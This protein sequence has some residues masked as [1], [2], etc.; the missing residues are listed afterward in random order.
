MSSF[1]KPPQFREMMPRLHSCVLFALTFSCTLGVPAAA[2]LQEQVVD[3]SLRTWM[4]VAALPNKA[5]SPVPASSSRFEYPEGL[6]VDHAGDLLIVASRQHQVFRMT[7]AG[8]IRLIAGSGRRGFGG[9]GGPAVD[10]SLDN[11][12]GVVEDLDANIVIA[13]TYNNRIR[14]VDAR[15]GIITTIAGGGT[16]DP[17]KD[18]FPALTASLAMPTAL[19]VDPQGNLLL[20]DSRHFRVRRIDKNSGLIQAV[21][22]R[23]TNRHEGDGGPATSSDVQLPSALA[24]DQAGNVFIVQAG[25][26]R[27]RRVDA[28]TGAIS[29]VA[30][31]AAPGSGGD[32]GPATKAGLYGPS[33]VAVDR[34]GN[35]FI[36]EAF[37]RRIRRVDAVTGIITTVAGTG[38]RGFG[39]NGGPAVDAELNEPGSLVGDPAGNLYFIELYGR[40]IRKVDAV[41]KS[42]SIVFGYKPGVCQPVPPQP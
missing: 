5:A 23:G 34:E 15:T 19:A 28:R 36:S 22:G 27:V 35:L 16:G 11:P 12:G 17:W 6:A 10:A 1:G 37:S 32:G 24:V 18:G 30:G 39:G 2:E 21:A 4:L 14:R 20:S 26:N 33:G 42:L 3:Q 13:D 25:E 40:C 29:T 38:A 7:K 9:D 31:T 41:T 8:E